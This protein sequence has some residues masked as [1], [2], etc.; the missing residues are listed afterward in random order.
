MTSFEDNVDISPDAKA[1][2]HS[3]HDQQSEEVELKQF[4][5]ESLVAA[6]LNSRDDESS[7]SSNMNEGGRLDAQLSS[8]AASRAG[9]PRGK[10]G[11]N[12]R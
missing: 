10:N 11:K 8:A 6:G 3:R 12:K 1:G 7:R 5:R 4:G 9:N 2:E